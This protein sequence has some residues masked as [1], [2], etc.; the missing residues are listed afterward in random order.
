[1]DGALGAES[2]SA[3]LV[4]PVLFVGWCALEWFMSA[5]E[6]R[7]LRELRRRM[8]DR[9][10]RRATLRFS[11]IFPSERAAQDAAAAV[12]AAGFEYAVDSH[13]SALT[14][15]WADAHARLPLSIWAVRR[16]KRRLQHAVDRHGGCAFFPLDLAPIK[17]PDRA[18]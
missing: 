6:R 5:P 8:P 13:V 11:L 2:M 17:F 1:M 4:I 12:R 16:A 15:R 7:Q 10:S 3:L 18:T 14:Q 9:S